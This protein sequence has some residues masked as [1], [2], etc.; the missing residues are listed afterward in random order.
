MPEPYK[1]LLF[2]T[3]ETFYSKVGQRGVEKITQFFVSSWKLYRAA[4]SFS[5]VIFMR[6]VSSRRAEINRVEFLDLWCIN[7]FSR[8]SRT[9]FAPARAVSRQREYVLK[10]TKL[11]WSPRVNL[12][13]YNRCEMLKNARKKL[14]ENCNRSSYRN[15][16]K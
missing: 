1:F 16:V 13:I 7:F 4:E 3:I 2:L 6:A 15:E 12:L 5:L 9:F 14:H 8:G 11:R 10:L